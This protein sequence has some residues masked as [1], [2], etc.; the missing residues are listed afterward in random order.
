MRNEI[1]E[2]CMPKEKKYESFITLHK[3]STSCIKNKFS[4][5]GELPSVEYPV[6]YALSGDET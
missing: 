1:Y 5:P 3:T 4:L 6:E 2:K